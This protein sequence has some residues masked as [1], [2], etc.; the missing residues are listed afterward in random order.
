MPDTFPYTILEERF[1]PPDNWKQFSFE[2]PTSAH[3]VSISTM[4]APTHKKTILIL[5]GLSEFSEKYVETARFFFDKG[6]DIY[7]ID[8][9]YQGRSTR[10]LQNPHKRHSDGYDQDLSDIDYLIT[11]FVEP[12]KDLFILAHSMGGHIAMR[13]LAEYEH[14]IK[15]ASFSAPML[16]I[17]SL[18]FAQRIYHRILSTFPFLME[19]YVPGG[20]DWSERNQNLVNKDIFSSDPIRK[21]LHNQWSKYI[22]ELQLGNPTLKWVNETLKSVFILEKEYQ[23]IHIPIFIAIGSD[24]RLIC[25]DEI[26]KAVA[27]MPNTTVKVLKNSKHE[28]M[29]EVDEIRN[30]FL[31]ETLQLFNENSS[32]D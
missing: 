13:Y 10:H 11:H 7:I 17:K 20:K 32:S 5:T 16:K 3:I 1:I 15:A 2:N 31:T 9:A 27:L 24:E 4:I 21:K 18:S 22:P 28:I 30:I 26:E 12:H 25:N 19:Q 6:F 8:W 23:N 29:M 14:E